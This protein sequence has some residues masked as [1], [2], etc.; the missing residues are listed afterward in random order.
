[1]L[2]N[3]IVADFLRASALLSRVP[4]RA[5]FTRRTAQAAWAYPVVGLWL[6]LIGV[7]AGGL[8]FWVGLPA[9]AAAALVLLLGVVLTGAMHEDGLADAADGLWG[10]FERARRLDI[11]RDSRI[12]TY[13]VLALCLSLLLRFSALVVLLPTAPLALVCAAV[14][15]R[16]AMVA[17]MHALPHA[18]SDGLSHATGRPPFE[19]TAI[20]VAIGVLAALCG[21]VWALVCGVLACIGCAR[22]AQAKI[23]GQTGDI[24]GATQ[25]VVEITVLL[26]LAATLG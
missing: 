23:G 17:V 6:G 20:A 18:R 9:P 3:D 26:S 10:G 14:A 25:Q 12:G 19:A 4:L 15:S 8:V 1:M 7:L 24:L 11:M 2:G 16:G 13:G 5:D 21:G 22:L